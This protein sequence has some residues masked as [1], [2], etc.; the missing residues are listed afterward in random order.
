[1]VALIPI[2]F[3]IYSFSFIQKTKT[4]KIQNKYEDEEE[5]YEEERGGD[6]R[7]GGKGGEG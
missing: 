1:M 6:G 7:R 3:K 5:E 4:R 2:F